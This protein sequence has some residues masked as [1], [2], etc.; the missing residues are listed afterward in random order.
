[1]CTYRDVLTSVMI[2]R[3]CMELAVIIEA[4]FF[5]VLLNF[6]KVHYAVNTF[7]IPRISKIYS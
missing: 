1:M 6:T 5:V 4:S 3:N 2:F 7:S